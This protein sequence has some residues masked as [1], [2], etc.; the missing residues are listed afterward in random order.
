MTYI[1]PKT[2]TSKEWLVDFESAIKEPT[3]YT[4]NNNV[5]N[6]FRYIDHRTTKTGSLVLEFESINQ[7]KKA[8]YF[9]NVKIK[10]SHGNNYPS[11]YRGQFNPPPRGKFRK[12]WLDT[13]GKEPVRWC[14]IHK[15]LRSKLCQLTFTGET[16][17]CI[18]SNGR[19]YLKLIHLKRN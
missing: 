7:D 4:S 19:E 3:K 17:T 8:V 16:K 9:F 2:Q 14:R 1:D 18:D 15:S 10:S 11:G 6:Q 5:I 12:F 13:V